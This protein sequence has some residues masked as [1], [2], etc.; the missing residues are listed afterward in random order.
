MIG[1]DRFY[2]IVMSAK[3]NVYV[4]QPY[5]NSYELYEIIVFLLL[6]LMFAQGVGSPQIQSLCLLVTRGSSPVAF[7]GHADD[8]KMT[9]MT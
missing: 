3:K 7:N 5:W 4:G 1:S 9:A 8:R 2:D 6:L